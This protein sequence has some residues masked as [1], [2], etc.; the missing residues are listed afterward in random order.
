MSLWIFLFYGVVGWI[1]D[2]GYRT[3]VDKKWSPG[4]FSMLP[5]TPSYGAAA[6]LLFWAGPLI[7]H[8]PVAIQLVVLGLVFGTFE[9]VCG[10]L[11]ILFM[12][13]RLWDYSKGFWN[14]HGHAD[15][16]HTIYWA[17]LS[18]GALHWFHPW[19]LETVSG[20]I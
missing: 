2:S 5:F 1:I 15:L 17:F 14:I 11:S 8:W 12:R 6:V 9:Y 13:K 19:L 10:H 3:L 4:G 18:Y 7:M 16:L 20:F